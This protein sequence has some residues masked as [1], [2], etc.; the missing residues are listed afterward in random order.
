MPIAPQTRS[1]QGIWLAIVLAFAALA[2]TF[3]LISRAHPL[4]EALLRGT[5]WALVGALLVYAFLRRSLMTWIF[6][7]MVI[8]GTFGHEFP[9]YAVKFQIVTQIF[10]RLIKAIIA[11]LIFSTLVVG[12]AGH[13]DLKQVGRMGLKALVYFEVV[14]TLA[15]IIGLTAI[16]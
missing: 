10:L 13:S 12:I 14:T 11:P 16:N 2:L 9:Q 5:R 8:G 15:L 6:A 4:P 7:C 1:K 3:V